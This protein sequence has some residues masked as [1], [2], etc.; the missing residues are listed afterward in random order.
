MPYKLDN[1]FQMDDDF[2][3]TGAY[4]W[5]V[6]RRYVSAVAAIRGPNIPGR[7]SCRRPLLVGLIYDQSLISDFLK[8]CWTQGNRSVIGR[9]EK[10]D[11]WHRQFKGKPA[12]VSWLAQYLPSVPLTNVA[13]PAPKPKPKRA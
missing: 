2:G 4:T 11:E 9:L 8:T 12:L 13:Q 5:L 3:V 6:K 10:M 7:S 1:W